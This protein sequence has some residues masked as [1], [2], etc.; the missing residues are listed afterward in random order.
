MNGRPTIPAFIPGDPSGISRPDVKT[1]QR[2]P[3]TTLRGYNR[4]RASANIT[5]ARAGLRPKAP[6]PFPSPRLN[7]PSF[8]A[9]QLFSP[10]GTEGTALRK[11]MGTPEPREFARPGSHPCASP[12]TSGRLER[13]W[14]SW[15]AGGR[16]VCPGLRG[17]LAGLRAFVQPR[18]FVRCTRR[19]HVEIWL[20]GRSCCVRPGVSK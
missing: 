4:S 9:G 7:R 17:R 2:G 12:G 15:P 18:S 8:G 14:G 3:R 11:R 20:P 13:S 19:E 1:P 10:H 16:R 5:A 6:S